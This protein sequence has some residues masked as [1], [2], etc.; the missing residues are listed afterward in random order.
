MAL[1]EAHGC[2]AL[3][4]LVSSGAPGREDEKGEW[5]VWTMLLAIPDCDDP[6]G[7][8]GIPF[9]EAGSIFPVFKGISSPLEIGAIGAMSVGLLGKIPAGGCSDLSCIVIDSSSFISIV[10]LGG[11]PCHLGIL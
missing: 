6:C 11:R 1:G 9:R 5:H 4:T 2:G 7:E 10:M 3:G 8:G